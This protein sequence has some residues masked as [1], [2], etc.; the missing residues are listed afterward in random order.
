MSGPALRLVRLTP[1]G[2]RSVAAAAA[3][4]VVAGLLVVVQAGLLAEVITRAFL[5]GA[6]I[7]QSTPALL[8]LA[9]VVVGRAVLGW[10]GEVA[11]D[12]GGARVVASVRAR[13]L[14]HV[15][16]LGPRHP[17]LPSTGTLAALAGRGVDA[18]DGY[19]G[20]YLPQRIVAT[21]VPLVV[22]I[23]ILT[24][25]WLS[26][27]LLV[28][29]VPLVPVFMVLIGLHTR[30]R[31][32]RQWRTLTVLAGHFLDV[33]TG[34]EV[35]TAF[36]RAGRQ[37]RRI[38]AVSEQHRVQTMRSLR[39]AFLSALTLELLA[40]L[41]VA[42]VAVSVGLRLVA[43][44]LDLGTGLL[45]IMLAPEV[46]LPLRAV[47]AAYHDSAEGAAAA[48]QVLGVL[49]VP[50][51]RPV[52]GPAPDP[53]AGAVRLEAVTVDGRA[54][55][56]L[57]QV[58]LAIGP[59]EVL[60]LT[61]VSGA[62]KSTVLDLLLG[63]RLPDRGRVT[64]DGIDLADVDR[65]AWLCR[66]SWVPQRPGLV[67]GTVAGNLR[68][69]AP[70]ATRA[71]LAAAA[72]AVALE[73]PLATRVHERG[74]GLSTGQQR[75]VALARALLADRPLLLLDEPTEGL[76]AGTEAALLETLPAALAGRTAVVV[77][78]RAA[79]LGLCDRVVALA[80]PAV[81]PP[82][83]PAGDDPEPDRP[84]A[85]PEEAVPA[86]V[87]H[88]GTATRGL[89]ALLP[90]L[91]PHR[92]RIA[93]AVLAGTGASGCALALAATS[94][95]LIS[96]AALQPPVLSLMV[97]IVGVRTFALAKAGLRYGERL[98][99]HDAA[100]RILATLRT[101]LWQA[102]V[103]LGPAATARLRSGDLLAR[104]V[105]DV[106]AQR[107]LV[108]RAFVPAASAALV[109]VGAVAALGVLAPAAGPPPA[110]GALFARG[111]PPPPTPP[112]A[113]GARPPGT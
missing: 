90:V 27:L 74:H 6:G 34:L 108:V 104:L 11:A 81:G 38:A 94:A 78:H 24:A 14:D 10:A 76:D 100:L 82:G 72:S 86:A 102:L 23:R 58:S 39:V 98:A 105:G 20:R 80:G 21:V 31:V 61:G 36:G 9:G 71:R 26:G 2:S 87:P 41:S 55:P 18:L 91:R 30:Q 48:G 52:T 15:L 37:S 45:V 28:V 113:R 59:G 22:G 1:G 7:A 51:H 63:W 53:A 46:F 89:R 60:G 13:L 16:L 96:A 32:A 84:G 62:G 99:S 65:A 92:G 88:D 83:P 97:A 5:G 73:L 68:L 43:G 33:V 67:R 103:R 4:S 70:E 75:R 8:A 17:D 12:R 50:V 19:T 95:W 42:L 29:T 49:D 57:D 77:S 66:V 64:V 109:A 40:S 3:L 79:V 110:A 69:A 111:L 106:D 47:S 101:R 25:D 112:A 44:E 35:L 85:A 54:G 56:V 93:R 107:D